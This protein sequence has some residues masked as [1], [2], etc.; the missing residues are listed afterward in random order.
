MSFTCEDCRKQLSS[1]QSLK[2]HM[3]KRV[4]CNFACRECEYQADDRHKWYKHMVK[5]HPPDDIVE[6]VEEEEEVVEEPDERVVEEE[7]EAVEELSEEPQPKTLKDYWRNLYSGSPLA[8]E[9]IEADAAVKPLTFPLD[10]FDLEVFTSQVVSVKDRG[11]IA[12]ESTEKKNKLLFRA[13]TLK[14]EM[15]MGAIV[16]ALRSLDAEHQSMDS[17]INELLYQVHTQTDHPEMQAICMTDIARRNVKMYTRSTQDDEQCKWMLHPK[18]AAMTKVQQH[19]R[20]LFSFLIEV[21]LQMLDVKLWTDDRVVLALEMEGQPC[22]LVIWYDQLRDWV[23]VNPYVRN[24]Q[25]QEC[26]EDRLLDV[27]RMALNIKFRKEEIIR[28]VKR[29]QLRQED[30]NRFLDHTRSICYE[31]MKASSSSN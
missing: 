22:S 3:T 15:R 9:P 19:A 26:P 7:E 20:N 21:G 13:K 24:S 25:F 18:E 11:V 27:E 6:E 5:Q 8:G 4:P 30:L 10:D 2:Q 17:L 29:Y 12:V 14:G 16:R 28:Q 23:L 31:S 1:K